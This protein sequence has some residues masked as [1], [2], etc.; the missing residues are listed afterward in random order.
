MLYPNFLGMGLKYRAEGTLIHTYI[1]HLSSSRPPPPERTANSEKCRSKRIL[2]EMLFVLW[3]LIC[4]RVSPFDVQ[5]WIR[6]CFTNPLVNGRFSPPIT[7]GKGR[8]T[9]PPPFHNPNW[10]W[11]Q[12]ISLY[13]RNQQLNYLEKMFSFEGARQGVLLKLKASGS[14][15]VR[16]SIYCP[17]TKKNP[18]ISF[19]QNLELN[20]LFW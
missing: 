13:T 11:Y 8:C 16:A 12:T 17:F 14:W 9:P 15:T 10:K 20:R 4:D 1:I 5:I 3:T 18:I 7:H 6:I 19:F 2:K